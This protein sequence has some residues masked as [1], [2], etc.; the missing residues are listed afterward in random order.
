MEF[1]Q[2]VIFY[3]V[4]FYVILTLFTSEAELKG[5]LVSTRTASAGK[6]LG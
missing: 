4:I 3:I 1:G 6:A 2:L 5:Y